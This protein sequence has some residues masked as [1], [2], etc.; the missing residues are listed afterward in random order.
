M[1]QHS[2]QRP[3]PALAGAGAGDS[4]VESFLGRGQFGLDLG[5]VDEG[6]EGGE[7]LWGWGVEDVEEVGEPGVAG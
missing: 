3:E 1:S 2:S 6:G 5:R 7:D 4:W